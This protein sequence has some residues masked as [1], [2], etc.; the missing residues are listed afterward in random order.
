MLRR[1]ILHLVK[2]TLKKNLYDSALVY[3]KEANVFATEMESKDRL[4]LSCEGLSDIYAAKKNYEPAYH[5]LHQYL[6][7]QNEFIDSLNISTVESLNA[8]YKSA[9]RQ[10]NIDRLEKEKAVRTIE[11]TKQTYF[12]NSLL[13]GLA[14]VLVFLY[15]LYKRYKQRIA[16]SNQLSTSLTELK[17][18]Q[19]QLIKIEKEKE[20]EKIRVRISRDIHD[21]IGSNLTKISLLSSISVRNNQN[22]SEELNDH[23]KQIQEYTHN[24]NSSLSEIVWAVTPKQDSL[25]SLVEYMKKYMTDFFKNTGI[26]YQFNHPASFENRLLNPELKRNIFLVLKESL[27]NTLKYAKAITVEIDLEIDDDNFSLEI[28]DNGVGFNYNNNASGENGNGLTNMNSRMLQSGGQ[29]KIK[30]SNGN[31]TAIIASGKLS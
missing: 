12:K 30:S 8:K 1:L 26:N 25:E 31:G 6:E 5:F 7:L 11:L 17:S 3:L 27:N 2:Y 20:A 19:S 24:V 4:R 28:K 14:V 18:A 22:G 21:E 29:L 16:L 13:I 23:L 9:E 15:M 10:S